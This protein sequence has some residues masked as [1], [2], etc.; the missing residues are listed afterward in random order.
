MNEKRDW[1]DVIDKV[2]LYKVVSVLTIVTTVPL[3]YF[4]WI[5]DDNSLLMSLGITF[6]V[7]WGV[8]IALFGGLTLVA[9]IYI[10]LKF[11]FE[12]IKPLLRWFLY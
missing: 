2:N 1:R 10:L 5:K 9:M 3:F 8:V 6:M 12:I 4:F 7:L 11:V